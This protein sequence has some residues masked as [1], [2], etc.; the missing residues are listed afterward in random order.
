[1]IWGLLGAVGA[2]VCYG[3]ASILQALAARDEATAEGLDPRLLLRLAHSWRY[4]LGLGLDGLAFLLSLAALQTMPLFAVQA[5]V[6]SF[7]AITAVLGALFLQMPLTRRDKVALV[8]VIGGLVMVGMSAAEDS[9]VDV[10]SAER[11][12]VLVA[13]VVLAVVAVP[14]GRVNG[15]KGAAALGAVAGLGFGTVAVAARILPQVGWSTL[16]GDLGALLSDP[17]TYAL[18]IATVVALLSYSTAL[19]RGT[20]TQATAPLVVAETVA[21]ALVGLFMLGD[22]PREGWGWVAFVG[23]SLAVGGAVALSRHGDVAVEQGPGPAVAD[24][25]SAS[26]SPA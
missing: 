11:W 23:F 24:G 12:G 17:A 20:V 8:V 9:A 10:S 26:R 14:L 1:M 19:Q 18:A 13:A 3:C 25:S 7:L 22:A 21:P 4:L 5:I 16:V 6:A 2:A 15:A